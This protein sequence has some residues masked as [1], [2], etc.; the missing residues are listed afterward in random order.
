MS[1]GLVEI[2]YDHT[3][4]STVANISIHHTKHEGERN[5]GKEGRVNFTVTWDAIRIDQCLSNF[6]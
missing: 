3:H 2:D 1:S 4:K 6:V 5:R